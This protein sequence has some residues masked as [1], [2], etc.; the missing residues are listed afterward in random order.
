MPE[1]IP[2]EPGESPAERFRRLVTQ[3][4]EAQSNP[5]EQTISGEA[6]SAPTEAGVP[7]SE[8]PGEPAEEW[9]ETVQRQDTQTG[10]DSLPQADSPEKFV[11][12]ASQLTPAYPRESDRWTTTQLI[13]GADSNPESMKDTLP[14]KSSEPDLGKTP[15]HGLKVGSSDSIGRT[16]QTLPPQSEPGKT[17]LPQP[18]NALDTDAT[19]VNPAAYNQPL[20]RPHVSIE[21]PTRPRPVNTTAQPVYSLPAGRTQH[22]FTWRKGFGCLVR[23]A[24]M[25]MFGLIVLLLIGGSFALSQYYSIASTLPSIDDL[26]QRASQFETTRIL[27]RNGNNLYEILDPSAGRRTY[28][29]LDKISPSLVAATIATEDKSFY[30]HPG[31]DPMAILRAFWQN[32]QG[33][34]TVSG[35]STI[36]QQLAR[37]LLFSPQERNDR[38]YLRKVREAILAAEITRRYSKNEILE[39]YL[40]EIPFG[41]LAYGVEAAAETYF[42]TSA[43]KLSLGQAAFLAGLPQAPSVYD[44]YKNRDETLH[45]MNDVLVLMIEASKAENC[46]HVSNSSQPVC[47]DEKAALD[48]FNEIVAY[49]FTTP[50]INI[51]YPHWVD[52]IRSLLEAQYDSQTI[53]QSG[54]TV[55]TTL[56]PDMQD[57][58]EQIVKDQISQL[59]DKHATDGALVAI[60]PKSGEILAMVGSADYYNEE[61]HG[62]VN[63][64]TSPTRQPGSSIKP[65]TYLAA[66]EKGWT[67]ATLIWDVP[68]EF[69]PSGNPNDTRDPYKPDNYDGRFHGPVTVRTALANSYNVPAVKALQFV[70]IYDNPDTQ[71]QDGLINLLRRFGLTSLSR[72]DYGLS[73]TLGGGEVSLLEFTSAYATL[74]NGGMRMPPY[75]ITKI[76]DYNGNVVY[77]YQPPPGQQIVR[78]EHTYLITSILSD[79]EARTPAFGPNSVLSLPFQ[80]AAKTGTTN[81]FRDNWTM[82]YTPDLAVG[83]WVGNADYTPMQDTTGVTGAAPIWSQFMQQVEPLVSNGNPTPFT[84]PAGIIDRVICAT[85]GTDPSQ[86][87]PSQRSEIFASYQ[88]PL[89]KEQD[90]WTKVNFDTFTG[91]RASAACNQFTKEDIAL[92]V[93]DPWAIKWLKDTDAGHSWVKDNGFGDNPVYIPTRECKAEDPHPILEISSPGQGQTINTN[94]LDIL[95]KADA[96][97]DFKSWALDYGQGSDPVEWQS[98]TS[99]DQPVKDTGKL[100]SWDLASLAAG[101]VTL[102]LTVN[103]SK[104]HSAELKWPLNLQVPTP[105]PTPTPTATPTQVPTWTP[106]PTATSTITPTPSPTTA[107]TATETPV[108]SVTPTATTGP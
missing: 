55:Y 9:L 100:Y 99:S 50:D 24:I 84:R 104:D 19:R 86:W 20:R 68:S 11:S 61:I 92:N 81:D 1:S 74:A 6:L 97:G 57:K 17:H 3:P 36:T 51:R 103:S 22:G 80:A 5:E 52:Y 48:A 98:L 108:P 101:P 21:T 85:S 39:L 12:L 23:M 16:P 28:V 82:G 64:A 43:D 75:A 94:P 96:T 93:T 89:P 90:L 53:Y 67:P 34:E 72:N 14:E 77:Q 4:E 91:L 27:D 15:P 32:Y 10:P 106:L 54:F 105:T 58:A 7:P 18:V 13:N 33:G 30:T 44:I 49:H 66:F 26:R 42:R 102:R 59:T 56:D 63:M 8:E 95:G 38:S 37:S 65:F 73:L 71:E 47:V 79:N 62:Q 76:L 46:I 78:A 31:F 25:G 88:P 83:V 41:N 69:P 40:N 35:A 107:P 60:S 29:K 2:T 70:G 45:R 87:C